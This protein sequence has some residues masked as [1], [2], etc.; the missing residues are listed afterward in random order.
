MGT[1][2]CSERIDV[3]NVQEFGEI[4]GIS[5][6]LLLMGALAPGSCLLCDTGRDV[7]V[8]NNEAW[9]AALRRKEDGIL[10]WVAMI[11]TA[12]ADLVVR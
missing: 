12:T 5:E 4:S 1:I 9:F 8:M 7:H 11:P 3:S 6:W 2:T 10:C